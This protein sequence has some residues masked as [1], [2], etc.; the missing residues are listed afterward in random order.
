MS[1]DSIPSALASATDLPIVEARFYVGE[2]KLQPVTV[3][4]DGPDGK[5]DYK[6]ARQHEGGT[7]T[8]TAAKH[9]TF[10]KAT[11]SGSVQMLIQNPAAFAVFREAFQRILKERGR[12][13]RFRVYFV[14]DESQEPDSY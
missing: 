14:E 4:D 6:T 8:M 11:P 3:Y 5:P 9:G 2:I 1:Q 13:A 12:T 7:V 10:G